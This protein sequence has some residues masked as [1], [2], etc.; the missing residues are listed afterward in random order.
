[1]ELITTKKWKITEKVMKITT[2]F[3]GIQGA[4]SHPSGLTVKYA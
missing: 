2:F 1:M 4:F 3:G